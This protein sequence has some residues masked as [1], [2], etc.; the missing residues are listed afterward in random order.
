VDGG[1]GKGDN[2]TRI[3]PPLHHKI[4]ILIENSSPEAGDVDI[5]LAIVIAVNPLRP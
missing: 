4:S 5:V 2:T 3:H 1:G